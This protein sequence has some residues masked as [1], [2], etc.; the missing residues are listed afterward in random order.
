M[1]LCIVPEWTLVMI[2]ISS[3]NS[4]SWFTQT[5]KTRVQTPLQ[6]LAQRDPEKAKEYEDTQNQLRQTLSALKSS[7]TDFVEQRKAAAREK[8][9]RLKEQIKTLRMMAGA[10]PKMIARQAAMLA[11][12]LAAAAKEY[13]SAGGT[14]VAVST[15]DKVTT[16]SATDTENPSNET[17]GE[18]ATEQ[19]DIPVMD[20][21]TTTEDQSA[22][23]EEKSAENVATDPAASFRDKMDAQIRET[24]QQDNAKQ[25][26][27]DFVTE[28][29]K[30]RDELK[31]IIRQQRTRLE[32]DNDPQIKRS[33][34]ESDNV[35]RDLDKSL[36]TITAQVNA[37]PT[38]NISA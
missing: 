3:S 6:A 27:R 29:K 25:M 33:L 34:N 17:G 30:L 4:S 19:T 8:I 11:K 2:D 36:E 22:I 1:P 38:L 5:A 10:D 20:K 13:A 35:L 15:S 18:A 32:N 9:R 24:I 23:A 14:D 28:V 26:D 37:P 16:P 12:E 7:K 21:I 31:T